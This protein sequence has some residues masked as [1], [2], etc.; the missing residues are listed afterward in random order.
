[1]KQTFSGNTSHISI[2][3]QIVVHSAR[4][5]NMDLISSYI[6]IMCVV[7]VGTVRTGRES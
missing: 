4:H 6:L 1:M 7:C 3:C 2:E 5:I